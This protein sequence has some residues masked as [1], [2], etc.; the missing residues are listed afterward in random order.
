MVYGL[1]SIVA[2]LMFLIWVLVT[3]I[4]GGETREFPAFGG[5]SVSLAAAMGQGYM[6]QVFMIPF[7]IK[8]KTEN[9]RKTISQRFSEYTLYAYLIGGFIYYSTAY[10]GSFGIWHRPILD[11]S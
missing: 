11:K 9:H 8:L 5:S 3:G 1:I 6:I 10:L 4:H 2:Y 7:L